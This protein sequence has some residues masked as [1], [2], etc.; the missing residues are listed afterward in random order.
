[1]L[2]AVIT[3]VVAITTLAVC[4]PVFSRL[5]KS[6]VARG[7]RLGPA[8]WFAWLRLLIAILVFVGVASVGVS[9]GQPLLAVPAAVIAAGLLALAGNHYYWTRGP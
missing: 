6:A 9:V 7:E 8:G 4:L 3:L 1:M 2:T 5:Y